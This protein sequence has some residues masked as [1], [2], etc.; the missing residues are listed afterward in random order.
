MPSPDVLLLRSPDDPDPYLQAFEAAGYTAA[1]EPVLRFVFPNQE[2]LR[3]RLRRADEVAGLIATSPRVGRALHQAYRTEP[4]LRGRWENRRA[5]AVGPKTARWLQKLGLD[6]IGEDTGSAA[7][8]ADLIVSGAHARPLL[9]LSGNRRRDV[10][11][12]RL[13]DAGVAF[14]EQVV[15]ETHPRSTLDVPPPSETDWLV[16]FSPSGRDALAAADVPLAAYRVA[17]IG[18]TTADA[19]RDAG[20]TVAAVAAAPAPEALVRAIQDADAA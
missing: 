3:H 17:A 16:V 14:E 4:D 8:L 5:Y 13:R 10:L 19:L 20:H 11:P 18:P 1:C 9:F 15:Y 2:A 7:A 12:N 6:V